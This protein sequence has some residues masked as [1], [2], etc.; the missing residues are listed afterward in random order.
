VVP[1]LELPD[2]A[3]DFPRA[4]WRS[5]EDYPLYGADEFP[6]G[7]RNP[8]FYDT[9]YLA[10]HIGYFVAGDDR[11]PLYPEDSLSLYRFLR[12]NFYAVLELGELDLVAEFI[13][14]FRQYGCTEEN[15]RQVRDGTRYLL[16]LY[17]AAG[18]RWM[19]RR[20]PG[21]TDQNLTDYDFIHKAW[22]AVQGLRPRV[23]EPAE[24]GT[25]G[26]IVR[27]WLPEPR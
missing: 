18:D 11:Y 22:T 1:G 14:N 19:N 26:G 21:E 2:E 9:A 6:D 20:E 24:D 17:H 3:D 15:D 13:D 27:T 16:D 7:A 12:E 4:F 8:T 23:P 10:T 25:Y 5:L